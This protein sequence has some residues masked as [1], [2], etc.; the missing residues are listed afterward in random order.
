MAWISLIISGIFET[1]AVSMINRLTIKKD[2]QTVIYIII[3]IGMS[4]VFLHYSLIY[5]PMGT[6]Y[7]IWTGISV[8]CS[9]LIGM[10]YFQESKSIYRILFIALILVSAVGLKLIS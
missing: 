4:L 6:A 2:W 8:M 3:G 9:S 7:A 1:F 5:I 10:I